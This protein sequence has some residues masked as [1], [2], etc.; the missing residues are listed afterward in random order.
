M[1]MSQ[2]PR[3]EPLRTGYSLIEILVVL[4]IIALAT[5]LVVPNGSRLMDQAMAQAVFFEFQ[6]DLLALRKE[7]NR[8]QTALVV[9]AAN[10]TPANATER[11]LALRAGWTYAVTP[12]LQ[13]DDAGA[14]SPAEVSIRR[15][16]VDLLNLRVDGADCQLIRYLPAATDRQ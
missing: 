10:Q 12:E 9:K 4:A 3:R 11:V 6:R 7:A 2:A 14:C 5:A 16:N 8:T 15:D 1:L 13:I